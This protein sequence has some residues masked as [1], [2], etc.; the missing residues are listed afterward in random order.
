MRKKII[1]GNWKM[2]LNTNQASL[3]LHKL[4][5][6]VESHRNIEIVLCPSILSLQSLSLQ[7]NHRK[8]KLGAQNCYW[9]DEGSFTGEVSASQLRGVVNYVIVGHSDRRH[10][11][12][13]SDIEVRQKVQAVIRNNMKPILCIGETAGE[14]ANNE[15]LDV[16]HGQLVAGL[17]NVTSEEISDVIIAYEPVWAIGTGDNAR[18]DEVA[19]TVDIIRHQVESLYGSQA[20]EAVRIVY[21]GSVDAHNARDYLALE[22]VDGLLIGGASLKADAFAGIVKQ[23]HE[24]SVSEAVNKENV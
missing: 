15:T 21:G 22:N 5:Q 17:A 1:A 14:R 6:K 18:A 20:A 19:T 24:L 7:V 10:K 11:F 2:H 23:A 12:G 3:Y 13:E 16:L 8:F 9:R 4:D